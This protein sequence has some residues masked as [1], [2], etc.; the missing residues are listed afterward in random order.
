[1]R[2]AQMEEKLVLAH[3]LKR[4][5]IVATDSTEAL[6]TFHLSNC[7]ET[8]LIQNELKLVGSMTVAPK[9]VTVQLRRRMPMLQKEAMK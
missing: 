9:S 3:L 1:M 6:C 7:F 5:D 2:L 8:L 4:F